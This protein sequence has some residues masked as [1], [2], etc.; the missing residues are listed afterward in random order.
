MMPGSF[1]AWLVA[2]VALVVIASA[3]LVGLDKVEGA[4]FMLVVVGPIVGG[5]IGAVAGAKGVSQGSSASTNP[6]PSS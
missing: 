3:V 1:T 4:D 5:V 2:L 6:P